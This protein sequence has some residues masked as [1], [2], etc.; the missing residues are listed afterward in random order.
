[1]RKTEWIGYKVHLTETCEADSLYLITHAETTSSVVQDVSTTEHIH[2][3]L[4]DKACLPEKHMVEGGY[5]DAELLT[6]SQ[7]KHGITL[8][9]PVR[10]LV[11]YQR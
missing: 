1:M 5:T 6:S 8:V 9:G 10:D 4:A 7:E 11:F 3:A 2:H